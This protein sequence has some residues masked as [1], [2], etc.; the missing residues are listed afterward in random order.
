MLGTTHLAAFI[1]TGIGL[2]LYPGPDT[3]YIISR[4]L[5]QG[6]KAGVLSFGIRRNDN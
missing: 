1:I 4:S 2:N 3:M 5:A 6:R